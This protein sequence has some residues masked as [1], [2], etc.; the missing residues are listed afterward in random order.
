MVVN[1]QQTLSFTTQEGVTVLVKKSDS[2]A[3]TQLTLQSTDSNGKADQLHVYL[4]RDEVR[5][6]LS[7]IEKVYSPYKNYY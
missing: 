5:A 6:L 3:M 7:T 2:D 4:G 1:V